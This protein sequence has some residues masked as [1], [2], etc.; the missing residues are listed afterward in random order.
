MSSPLEVVLLPVAIGAVLLSALSYRSSGAGLSSR[1][2]RRGARWARRV[3]LRQL[4]VRAPAPVGRL[5][6]GTVGGLLRASPVAAERA[7]SVAVVGPT[8]SGK[9]TEREL[10][11]RVEGP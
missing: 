10:A 2:P 5:V 9:T 7:Q 3:D 8:Q 4:T 11:F 6:L 1:R